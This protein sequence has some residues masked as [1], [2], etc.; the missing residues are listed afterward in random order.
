MDRY[1]AQAITAITNDGVSAAV[2]IA[3]KSADVLLYQ[4]QHNQSG[5]LVHLRQELL[6][7]GWMLIRAHPTM[8]PLVNLVNALLWKIDAAT[9]FT[10]G[11]QVIEAAV[12]EFKRRLHVHEAAIAETALRLI[13]EDAQIVTNGRSTTVR[14]ALGHAQRAGRRFR[15]ICAEGRPACEGRIM[16]QELAAS[17]ISTTLVVDALAVV[18]A[19][20]SQLV[21]V[22]ADHL[23]P[24]GLMNKV[25]TYGMVL[26]ANAAGVPVYALCSSE[27]FLPPAYHPP[28]Q[29]RWPAEQVWPEVPENIQVA[30]VYF[31]STPLHALAGIVT[32]QGV[33]PTEGI[34]AWLAAM[35]LNPALQ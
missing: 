5:D 24:E 34:E 10:E 25:G 12:T 16:A 13:P 23:S 17:G 30:N 26:S 8:A 35:K 31:D 4:A 27:K 11:Q 29:A 15:V 6:E 28:Q 18:L 3:A 2:E 32:E 20:E 14:A 33:Q 22:G 7:A 21:L 1:A 19:G 9:S